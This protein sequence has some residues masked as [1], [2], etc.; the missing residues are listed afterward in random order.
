M[1]LAPRV[2]DR[3]KMVEEISNFLGL[4]AEYQH[5][6]SFAYKIGEL[7]VDRS[8]NIYSD[9]EELLNKVKTL[10]IAQGYLEEDFQT[11]SAAPDQIQERTQEEAT[12]ISLSLPLIEMQPSALRN[13]V[14]ILYSKQTLLNHSTGNNTLRIDDNVIEQLKAEQ[15]ES[16]QAFVELM[17]QFA[18]AG[19]TAG[20]DF[21]VDK[22]T[23]TFGP[24]DSRATFVAFMYLSTKI[25]DSA[26]AAKRVY[27]E[28]VRPESEKYMMRSWLVR[29]G[30]GG[31]EFKSIR[32]HLL[33]KLSGHTA[34]R[35]AEAARKHSEK[36]AALRKAARDIQTEEQND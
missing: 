25:L 9:N 11:E 36:Y 21:E 14:F 3:K 28:H 27:P 12:D 8:G 1:T 4:T 23:L 16:V 29:M 19:E 35:N 24:L 34:F 5:A 31:P 18:R 15:L 2:Q 10:L 7:T 6:P 22:L 26:K 13:L 20:V 30:M 32:N 17:S 33:R